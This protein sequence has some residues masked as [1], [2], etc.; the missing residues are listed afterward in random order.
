MLEI[1][2]SKAITLI[3]PRVTVLV[4]TLDAQD[5][6]NSSPYS[7][8]YPLSYNPP[9]V[10]VAIGSKQKLTYINAKRTGEFVVCIV[11]TC[12]GQQA[13]DCAMDHQPGDKLWEKNGLQIEPSKQVQ[14]PRIK[15]STA[16]LECTVSAFLE[17]GGSHLIMVGKIVQAQAEEGGLEKIDP[18]MH[19]SNANF[20]AIGK[21]IILKWKK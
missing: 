12:I 15:Q 1:P 5:Q 11:P 21:E 17:F 19:E 20:R 18:L 14:V 2:I 13:F 7:W 10:G 8:I 3:S 9:M 6:V 16:S 4:N